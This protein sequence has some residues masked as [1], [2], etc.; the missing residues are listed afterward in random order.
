MHKHKTKD[1]VQ[2]SIGNELV[3]YRSAGS[4]Q[5]HCIA[6]VRYR[7]HTCNSRRRPGVRLHV[8]PTELYAAHEAGNS[9]S[10]AVYDYRSTA[11]T[12]KSARNGHYV[13]CHTPAA[14]R[15]KRA[16]G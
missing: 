4:T 3:N 6:R 16:A 2:P 8:L 15:D 11:Y 13:G 10:T 12:L 7:L 14:D 1:W 9:I 5:R